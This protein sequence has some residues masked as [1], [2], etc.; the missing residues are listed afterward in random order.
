MKRT[1]ALLAAGLALVLPAPVP[2]QAAL[3]VAAGENADAVSGVGSGP[4]LLVTGS[5]D[6]G[7]GGVS[8]GGGLPLD[9]DAGVRWG[10]GAGWLDAPWGGRL[11]L[12]L[13]ASFG[14]F[15]YRDPVLGASGGAGSADVHLYRPVPAGPV[16][17]R[18]RGGGRA[19]ILEGEGATVRRVLGRAGA[20]ATVAEGAV[21]VRGAADIWLAE[22]ASYPELSLAGAAAAGPLRLAARVSRWLHDDVPGTGWGVVAEVLLGSGISL[23]ATVSH[24]ATDI[25][26]F[27]PVQRSWSVG[28]RW[29]G[30]PRALTTP[31]VA[32]PG[33]AVR[34]RAPAQPDGSAV[35]LAGTFNGWQ[36]EP[37]RWDGGAWT[38]ELRLGPG[39]YEFAFVAADGTWFVPEGTPGRKPDGFGGWIATV[40]VQ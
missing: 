27:S 23:T 7:P 37:M 30:V 1:R 18:F 26:F 39:L 19:G 40:V 9:P 33:D 24:P 2:G 36:P 4:T 12:G 28:V 22:E 15:A 14:A 34:I 25:L 3:T 20:D 29:T 8:L 17:L 11:G 35:R 16:L 13:A 6:A 10:S 21:A 38:A 5:F 32:A 31:V